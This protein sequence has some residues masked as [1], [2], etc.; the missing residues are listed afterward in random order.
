MKLG[1]STGAFYTQGETE[2]CAAHL[3]RLPVDTCEVFLQTTSEYCAEFGRLVHRRLGQMPCLAVHPMGEQFEQA[4][5]RRSKRQEEDAFT[6]FEGVCAAG[7][8]LGARYYVFHGPFPVHGLL[9][10]ERIYALRE[11]FTRMQEVAAGHGL[12]VLWENVSWCALRTPEDVAAA[13][14]LL[15]EVGFVL[16]IKQACRAGVSPMEMLSAMGTSLRHVHVLD[17]TPEGK[18]C[19]PGQGAVDWARLG[20]MLRDLRYQGAVILEPYSGM[21]QAD[22]ELIQALAIL[23]CQLG[24]D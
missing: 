16:D 17:V 14:S 3:A 11:R 13:R 6:F 19:L 23:R 15:P 24:A 22:E 1:L 9:P 5:F 7:E 18:P 4:M 10:P 20:R 2:E 12:T 8:A 21:F